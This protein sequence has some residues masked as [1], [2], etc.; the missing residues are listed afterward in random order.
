MTRHAFLDECDA[1]QIN[2]VKYDDIFAALAFAN[3]HLRAAA[4]DEIYAYA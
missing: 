2:I 1:T 3:T 4:L